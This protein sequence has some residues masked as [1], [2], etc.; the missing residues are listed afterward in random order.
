[1]AAPEQ[2]AERAARK[3]CKDNGIKRAD[4]SEQWVQALAWEMGEG[5][6]Y[7]SGMHA[8]VAAAIEIDRAQRQPEIYIVQND[9][10]DVVDVF[11]D[12]GVAEAVYFNGFSIVE[13][14]VWEPGEYEAAPPAEFGR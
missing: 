3:V 14:T 5:V 4:K 9:L 6:T 7:E 8:L 11:R 2:I 1:M 10:G 12:K 13:D